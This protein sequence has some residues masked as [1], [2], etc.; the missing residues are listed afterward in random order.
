MTLAISDINRLDELVL[1]L[2]IR[3]PCGAV[4]LQ[5][6]LTTA[7]ERHDMEWNY[8]DGAINACLVRLRKQK[9]IKME[10]DWNDARRSIYS[11]TRK[12]VSVL[13]AARLFRQTL[14]QAG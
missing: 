7:A 8:S 4:E 2:L 3:K 12:G 14:E 11:V 9:M 6:R 5:Q 10:E 13:G 1:T